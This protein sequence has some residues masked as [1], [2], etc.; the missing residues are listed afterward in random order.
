MVERSKGS[1][2][3]RGFALYPNPLMQ[4]ESGTTLGN[5]ASKPP[6]W[7]WKS[8]G[9]EKLHFPTS[10]R[11]AGGPRRAKEGQVYRAKDD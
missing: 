4:V 6:S 9:S 3:A 8:R 1:K 7:T 10:E 11:A 5:S 2:E